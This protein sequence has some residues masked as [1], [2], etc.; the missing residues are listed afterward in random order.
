MVKEGGVGKAARA[1]RRGRWGRAWCEKGHEWRRR[2][3]TWCGQW[4][5]TRCL[6]WWGNQI[7]LKEG[8]KIGGWG[9]ANKGKHIFVEDGVSRDDD[10]VGDKVNTVIPLVVKGVAKE[11]AASGVRR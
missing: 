1:H 5:K 9:G 3:R 4:R 6:G 8:V 10:V 11:D 7:K 2:G